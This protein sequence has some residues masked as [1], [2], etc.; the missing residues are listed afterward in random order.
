LPYGLVFFLGRRLGDAFY[1]FDPKHKA[2]TYSNIKTALG[3]K[4]PPTKL[5]SLT[6]DF[7]RSF[8]Q[9][10]I[11]IFL[12][13]LVDKKYI[14]KYI[15]L[16]GLDNIAAG[17]KRGRG[18]ILAVVHEGSWEISNIISAHLGYPFNIIVRDQPRFQ[19]LN[20][21]L[22]LYRRQKGSKLIYRQNQTKDIIRALKEN[23]A[24]A[25]TVD[26]GG[27]SG[28]LVKFFGRDAS[29]STGAIKLAL[30]FGATIIPVFSTRLGGP[31]IKFFIDPPFDIKETQDSEKDI[32]DNLQRLV[33]LYE[34]R[35]AIYPK[36][37]LWTYKIWKYG[38]E[39][40]ILILSDAKAG[41]LR[42]AEGLAEIIGNHLKQKNE[43]TYV[44]TIEI[45]FKNKSSKIALALGS[46]FSGK[47]YCQGCL[48]CLRNFLLQETY[49]SI[50][51]IKPDIVISCG[52]SVVAVNFIVSR[53]NLAKSFIIMRPSFLS[54][55]RFDLVVM[56]RHDHPPKR[57]NIVVTDGALNLVNEE[58]L[59]SEGQ[60]LKTRAKLTKDFV[61]GLLIGGDT[62]NFKLGVDII[63]SLIVQVKESLEK[64]DGEL[65]VTTSRRTPLEVERLLKEEFKDYPRCKLLIIAN[66]N[67]IPEAVGGILALSRIIITSAESISMISEALSSRKYV[68]VFHPHSLS[69]KHER[70]LGYFAKNKY[71]YLTESGDLSGTISNIWLSKPK[72][73]I[74]RDSFLVG[75]AIKKIL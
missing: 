57:K 11:E 34:K 50:I 31:Y 42:Q 62:K 32:T 51:S 18:V 37:Y 56:N 53:E 13:P 64:L 58:Y 67:N 39:K 44:H 72:T 27:S 33:S 47:Y 43:K 19:R 25:M 30:K 71:L 8:G 65:L 74:L 66:E 35:L 38:R 40:N 22:N 61:L 16:E 36:E 17:F 1:Y 54:T 15:T 75:E 10:I 12:F 23:E 9:T 2:I 6:K 59:K 46:C 49:N 29:M 21:L 45:K 41:H 4:L 14:E 28:S 73:G 55:R 48:W 7:Y 3:D 20:K 24:I 52:S 68:L 26:Q 69:R 70:F 60:R 5:S 63:K